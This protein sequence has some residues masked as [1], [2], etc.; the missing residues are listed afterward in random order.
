MS[1]SEKPFSVALVDAHMPQ[2]DGF[3]LVEWIK[4]SAPGRVDAFVMLLHSVN[5]AEEAKRCD[6]VGAA[7]YLLKPIDHSE[8]F[9]TLL[10]LLCGD[11]ATTVVL[12]ETVAAPEYRVTGL[13]ILL[14]EDSPFNQKLALGVLGKRGHAV[15][16]A[17]NGREAVLLAAA[18]DFD[19]IFMD[20]Q[21]PE[22]DGL[23]ATRNIR[24]REHETGRRV[25]VIAMTAQ[26][27][28][29]MR[30]RCLSVGMDDYLVKPVR[31]REI[32]DKI[33]TLFAGL[34]PRRRGAA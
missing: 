24:A 27:M 3:S 18:H 11:D 9:D 22:M 16:V 20:I 31:A 5:R 13:R 4:R 17:N 32:Y 6:R 28:K 30:E 29:G 23:D 25:P 7:A 26:A 10:A 34:R 33:E 12:P 2:F 14:A 21:M 15:T 1:P 8:L 19:L